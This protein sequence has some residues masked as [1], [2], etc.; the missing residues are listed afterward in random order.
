MPRRGQSS[1]HPEHGFSVL[2]TPHQGWGV[3]SAPTSPAATPSL[4]P[5]PAPPE[6]GTGDRTCAGTGAATGHPRTSCGSD[7]WP[8]AAGSRMT[9]SPPGR[10]AIPSEKL[11][12]GEVKGPGS[13]TAG[14][15]RQGPH[16]RATAGTARQH[17]PGQPGAW[18]RVRGCG[19]GMGTPAGGEVPLLLGAAQ[20]EQTVIKAR[21]CHP[22]FLLASRPAADWDDSGG[23]AT[24]VTRPWAG[25]VPASVLALT[26]KGWW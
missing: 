25:G 16:G 18:G 3:A 23:R 14:T 9:C 26:T 13:A 19:H 1:R 20:R 2:L 8:P 5:L 15:P 10:L 11:S 7:L 17:S 24:A 6:P 21:W 22:K 4:T 12:H